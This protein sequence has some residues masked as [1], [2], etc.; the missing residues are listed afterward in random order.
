MRAHPTIVVVDFGSQ[1]TRLI[2]RRVREAGV[3][4]EVVSPARASSRI[5][6][7]EVRGVI[8]SG[9]PAS[10]YEP[11]APDV[12]QEVL[13][14]PLPVLGICYGM[15]LLVNRT[16]GRVEP[17][18]EREFG[19]AEFFCDPH[20]RLFAGWPE[21]SVVWM[22][23]GDYIAALPSG[24]RTSG[25]TARAPFAA[26]ENPEQG[27]Y[28]VQFHPEVRHTE[29]GDRLL[30]NFSRD[31]CGCTPDW[32]MAAYERE[33]VEEIRNQVGE[34]GRVVCALSGGVDSSV[35]ALL[36]HRAIGHRLTAVF[37]DNGLLRKGEAEQVVST[38]QGRYGIPVEA[39][40]ARTRFLAALAGISDPEE[41]RRRI[42]QTFVDV[43]EDVAG[44]IGA[45]W[46]AQGTIYPDRIESS[47]I[48][49]PSATIK[50]HHNV[51]GLPETMQ[52]KL[53]EPLAWLF[54][55]EVRDLGRRLGL[56]PA[57]VQRHPFPG[58]GLA[59]RIIG[60]V[61]PERLDLLREAD[62]IFREELESSGWM[63]QTSQAFA[64][65]LPVKTVGV[66]GDG[67]TYEQ[68][69]ALRSV[70]TED[71]MT[72][73]WSRLPHDLLAQVAGRIVGEVRGINRVVFD[74]TSKPPATI[75][76]E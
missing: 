60:E 36:V 33:A 74:I 38:F 24:M 32:T 43:F 67:R 71:F 41:K 3:Y 10:V 68:V 59:V 57:F 20:S 9:G 52:L 23:H 13:E 19:R 63:E 69:I 66:M 4:A 8:L 22:S 28:A 5:T 45:D 39:A 31:I 76:W 62:A 70:N 14:T 50:T 48:S 75:E 46:L 1:V 42:G 29:H 58:P 53:I 26:V 65:L 56:D 73:D 17:A 6:S 54:K 2:A 49:G 21:K 37:V 27:R 12:P 51:G 15:Q 40:D 61:T 18:P 16:G 30:A 44:R 25:H 34:D 11:G 35:M 7:P 47:A 64:V 55:D 72:A